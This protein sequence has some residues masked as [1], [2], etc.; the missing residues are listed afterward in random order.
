LNPAALNNAAQALN[1]AAL[2]PSMLL[3]GKKDTV[4]FY[5]PK[6]PKQSNSTAASDE[7]RF[8]N[9]KKINLF[10]EV[11]FQVGGAF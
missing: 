2:N 3:S 5:V 4:N 10:I 8:L 7:M 1:T 11:D 9:I 6:L